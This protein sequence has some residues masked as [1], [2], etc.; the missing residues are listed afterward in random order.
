MYVYINM[1][2]NTLTLLVTQALLLVLL[3]ISETLPLSASPY[4]GIIQALI[5]KLQEIKPA[6][7]QPP[8]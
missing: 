7:K 5:V 8:S 1:D 3:I 4:S 2:P 6:A